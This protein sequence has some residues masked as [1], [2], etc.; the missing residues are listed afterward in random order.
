MFCCG[1]TKMESYNR[2]Q[3]HAIKFCDTLGEG[4]TYTYEKILKAFGNDSLSR[5]QVFRWHKDIV[6]GRETVGDEPRYGR[7]AS[8][9]TSTN[10]DRVRVFSRHDRRLIIRMI[11][12][13]LNINEYTVHQIVTQ[14]LSTRKVCTKIVKK[15]FND[16][17][18]ARRIEMS[19]EMLERFETESVFFYL[20]HNR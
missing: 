11:A 6:N 18:K 5:A 13:E 7:P 4:T 1:I 15:K 10:V 12:D 19:A 8:V 17:Q 3:L 16:Y 2:E 20:G 14:V 9:R